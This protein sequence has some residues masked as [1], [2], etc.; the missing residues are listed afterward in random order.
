VKEKNIIAGLLF[1]HGFETT[2]AVRRAIDF[3]VLKT[4]I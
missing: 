3:A 4:Q 1:G 2:E